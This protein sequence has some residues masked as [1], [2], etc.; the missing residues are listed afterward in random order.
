LD[1]NILISKIDTN[2]TKA[3]TK[4]WL[5]ANNAS[6]LTFGGIRV[7]SNGD[8]FCSINSNTN[9]LNT[10]DTL[11]FTNTFVGFTILKLDNN[12][13]PITQFSAQSLSN[14]NYLPLIEMVND[15]IYLLNSTNVSVNL[16]SF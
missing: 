10:I 2:G 6:A 11:T 12:G 15:N 1:R 13:N 14:Q 3:W 16:G 4:S 7:S 8:V 5:R 9:V